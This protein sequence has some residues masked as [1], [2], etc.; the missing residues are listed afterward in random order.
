MWKA[1]TDQEKNTVLAARSCGFLIPPFGRFKRSF[2]QHIK[3]GLN[4][5]SGN[6]SGKM[7]CADGPFLSVS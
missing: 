4:L 6:R 3:T 2:T 1:G 5:E 7:R